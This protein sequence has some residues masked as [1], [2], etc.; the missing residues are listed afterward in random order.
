MGLEDTGE[1]PFRTVYLHGLIRDEHGEKMSKLRGNVI[2]PTEA[3]NEYGV[4]ALRFALASNSTP[5]NDIS[6]GKG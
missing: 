3:I 6:L 5:G 2:N 4:D 1:I